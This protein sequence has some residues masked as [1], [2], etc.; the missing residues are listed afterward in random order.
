M[1][2]LSFYATQWT[3]YLYKNKDTEAVKV[4][5]FQES[6]THYIGKAMHVDMRELKTL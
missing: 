5:S 1:F 4:L 3:R 2:V 6:D